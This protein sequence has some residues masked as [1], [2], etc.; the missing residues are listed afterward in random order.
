MASLELQRHNQTVLDNLEPGDRLQF[1]RGVYD[2]WAVYVGNKEV[3]HLSGVDG[4]MGSNL[5]HSCTISG[6]EFDKG[7]IRKDAFWDVVGDSKVYKNNSKD[8]KLKH[9]A[10]SKI[11]QR[12]LSKLGEVGYN[13]LFEEL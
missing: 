12:A 11:V 2:H 6:V 10:P 9:L 5:N 3:V 8:K 13:L 7:I 1:K 4:P